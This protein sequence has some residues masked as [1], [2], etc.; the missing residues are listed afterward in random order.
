[1]GVI[2]QAEAD[3]RE[4][5]SIPSSYQVL[6]MTA[7][8]TAHFQ[9]VPLNLAQDGHAACYAISGHW[10][11]KAYKAA[12]RYTETLLACPDPDVHDGVITEPEE[13]AVPGSKVSYVYY[14]SNE[15]ISG[16][17]YQSVPPFSYPLVC[18]MSSDFLSRPFPVHDYGLIFASAQKNV[19]P[20]GMSIVIIRDDLLDRAQYS[21]P[22]LLNY[23]VIAQSGSLLNTPNT[24]SIYVSGLVFQWIKEQGGLKAIQANNQAKVQTIYGVLDELPH[25]YSSKVPMTHRSQMNISF[26]TPSSELDTV[27]WQEAERAGLFYLRGHKVYGG[28][29]ASMY[30]AMPLEGALRLAEFMR[31]FALRHAA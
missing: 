26:F 13:W 28:I 16:T 25:F 12:G 2:H 7:G 21:T 4:I 23:S 14:C 6:F 24:F 3:L 29:R 22:D 5:L 31:D 11:R 9:A 20:A 18:D 10:S 30:N 8:G 1:M 15:T 19:G 17:Q 27:F